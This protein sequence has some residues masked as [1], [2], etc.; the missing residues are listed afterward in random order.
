MHYTRLVSAKIPFSYTSW[1]PK[2]V[3][4]NS[5]WEWQLGFHRCSYIIILIISSVKSIRSKVRIALSYPWLLE[6]THKVSY[7]W[8]F[9]FT[10][11]VLFL[12]ALCCYRFTAVINGWPKVTSKVNLRLCFAHIGQFF[13][14]LWDTLI[15][16]MKSLFFYK[17]VVFVTLHQIKANF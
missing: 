1:K 14:G 9:I 4:H 17:L 3:L 6:Q 16:I 7:S 15:S 12:L 11:S 13:S 10:S 2:P 5:M 8:I